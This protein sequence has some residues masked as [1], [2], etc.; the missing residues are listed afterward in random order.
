M[1]SPSIMFSRFNHCR[2]CIRTLIHP[3]KEYT[4]V[5]V[6]VLYVQ[7]PVRM[8]RNECGGQRTT[9]DAILRNSVSSRQISHCLGLT[10]WVILDSHQALGGFSCL[11][12]HCRD[13]RNAP[14]LQSMFSWAHGVKLGLCS[15]HFTNLAI[16]Q[17]P[18]FHFYNWIISHTMDILHFKSSLICWQTLELF[19]LCA[20][21]FKWLLYCLSKGK[22]VFRCMLPS[23]THNF[24]TSQL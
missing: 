17:T 9:L 22:C 15:N 23:I 4:C 6:G 1:S 11:P 5:G 8:Y 7:M 24:S 2:A 3:S 21:L 14:P 20:I 12:P 13:N 16:S 18:L 19:L 10:N